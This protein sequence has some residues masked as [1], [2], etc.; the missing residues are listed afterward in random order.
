MKINC[1]AIED[2][3]L[4]LKKI[5]EFIEQVDYLNLLQGFNSAID[6]IGYVKRNSVDLIFLDIRMKKLTGIQFLESLQNRPKVIITSAYDEYA[7]KGYELDVVDYLLKPFT[8]ERF[9]KPV[10]KVYNQLKSL[11]TNVDNNYIFV[12][13]ECRIE[14]VVLEDILFIQG[15][16]DYLQIHTTDRKLMILQTFKNLLDVLPSSDFQ[17]VHNSYVVAISKIKNIER[18]RIRIGDDLIPI[19]DSY[20]DKFY[21]TLKERNILI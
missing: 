19:S 21:K 11:N 10:D 7:L 1:I 8:F 18:N 3:P 16:K 20:K 9:L 5:M 17:R 15:M 2:E 12:K 14:K 6:A 4:A 13:T